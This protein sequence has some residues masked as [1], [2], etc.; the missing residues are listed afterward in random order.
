MMNTRRYKKVD[1]AETVQ[2]EVITTYKGFDQNLQCRGFQYAVGE[3]YEHDGEA[4]ACN[5]GFHAC[6]YPLDVLGYYAP[7]GSR[8]AIV[9]QSGQLS[10]HDD[11]SKVASTK[12]KVTAEIG[13]PGLIKAAIEYTMKRAKPEGGSIATGYQGAA[14]ATGDRG[15]ASATG[16]QGAASATGY[17]GAAS[18]TGEQGAAMASGYA[19][20]VM[21]K[22]GCALFLV[23]RNAEYEIIATWS[24]IAGKNG[25][26][27]DT[28]YML[29]DGKP[30][31]VTP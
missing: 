18:A 4:K 23:E 25:V 6:E 21:G 1:A 26:K 19:G 27:A 15:A 30:V 22:D 3:T 16:D 13:L 11:D 24:G 7:A 29:K 9:E 17:R 12:I 14:S 8:F 10:R 31:E 28:W 5:S 2:Q 20:R